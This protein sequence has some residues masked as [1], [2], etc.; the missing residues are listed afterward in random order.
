MDLEIGQ[1]IPGCVA[2]HQN[3]LWK[4]GADEAAADRSQGFHSGRDVICNMIFF[5]KAFLKEKEEKNMKLILTIQAELV[6]KKQFK[7]KIK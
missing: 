1:N 7:K 2:L 5:C 3:D 6:K 4:H